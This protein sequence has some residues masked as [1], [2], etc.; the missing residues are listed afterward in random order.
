MARVAELY[1]AGSHTPY[2]I[3]V[4]WWIVAG[5]ALYATNR[6]ASRQPTYGSAGNRVGR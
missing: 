4:S 3:M 2:G 6:K 1:G 5:F